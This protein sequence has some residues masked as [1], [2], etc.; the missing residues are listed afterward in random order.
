MNEYFAEVLGRADLALARIEE[1]EDSDRV[2][3]ELDRSVVF[4]ASRIASAYVRDAQNRQCEDVDLS[5][6]E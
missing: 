3:R 6:G 4:D 5:T 1:G 2:I